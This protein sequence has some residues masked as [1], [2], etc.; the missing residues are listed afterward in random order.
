MTS[1]FC[2]PHALSWLP[3]SRH[4]SGTGTRQ[5]SM[6]ETVGPPSVAMRYTGQPPDVTSRYWA[7]ASAAG[8]SVTF[9]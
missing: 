8:T 1:P 6:K 4:L 2:K 7:T 9:T 5:P 3:L